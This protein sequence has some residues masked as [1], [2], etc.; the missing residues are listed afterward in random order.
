MWK[1]C[2]MTHESSHS[3]Q[4]DAQGLQP[5]KKS[6][7]DFHLDASWAGAPCCSVNFCCNVTFSPQGG[8]LE[9][10]TF[11]GVFYWEG[12]GCLRC[13]TLRPKTSRRWVKVRSEKDKTKHLANGDANAPHRKNK[14]HRFT[15]APVESLPLVRFEPRSCCNLRGGNTA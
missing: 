2:L 10:T 3:M 9:A 8:N 14:R 15:F 6:F 13:I 11:F 4:T 12:G 7:H 1:M 5:K